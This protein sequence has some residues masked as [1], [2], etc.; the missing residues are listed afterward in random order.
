MMADANGGNVRPISAGP[1]YQPDWWAWSPDDQQLVVFHTVN[2]QRALSILEADGSGRLTSLDLGL[3]VPDGWAEWRPPDG[4]E[5]LFRGRPS[6]GATERTLY[7]IRP[8][9]T[10]LRS[11]APILSNEN[12]YNDTSVAPDGSRLL[13]WNWEADASPDRMGGHTHLLDLVTGV[14]RQ[15]VFDAT[16]ESEVVAAFSPDGKSILLER[17][18]PAQ[19]LVVSTDT[20]ARGV[21]IGPAFDYQ[22]PSHFGYSPD[23]LQVVLALDDASTQAYRVSDGA[24][25]GQWPLPFSTWQR[26]AP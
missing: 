23:G 9:G 3:V 7:A 21:T 12:A 13:Y 19:L 17:Q 15:M 26:L 4:R 6:P 2:D 10:G 11:I 20:G 22:T 24:S 8:D 25:L 5:I 18:L 14:E 1:L 16:A